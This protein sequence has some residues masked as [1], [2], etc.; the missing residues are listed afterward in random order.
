MNG[1]LN[2]SGLHHLWKKTK[3]LFGKTFSQKDGVFDVAN[4]INSVITQEDFD[5]LPPEKQNHGLYIIKGE[6]QPLEGAEIEEY[7]TTVD[8]CD[9]HVRKWS[10]GYLEIFG[11]KKY[12]NINNSTPWLV[13][14]RSETT[15][16]SLKFPITLT[17]KYTQSMNLD[18]LNTMAF[19][20]INGSNSPLSQTG[21]FH[22]V[23]FGNIA[24]FSFKVLPYVT[25][26]WK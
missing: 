16:P 7:D 15:H 5:A 6:G 13:F 23:T 24:T 21:N 17:K 10:N 25:G 8:G 22:V 12:E 1:F 3:S 14:Y 2:G 20:V 4:P 26:R 9:W 18:D 11:S 19:L